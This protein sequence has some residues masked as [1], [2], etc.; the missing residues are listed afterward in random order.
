MR[1]TRTASLALIA[2]LGLGV[3]GCA[4]GTSGTNNEAANGSSVTSSQSP[5][6]LD[7]TG[8]WKQSSDAG[9]GNE[10]IQSATI[11][12][13]TITAYWVTESDEKSLYW[14]GNVEVPE[15]A[16]GEFTWESKNDTSKTATALLASTSDTKSFTYK[17]KTISY[18][19]SALGKT[20]TVELEQT[21]STPAAAPAEQKQQSNDFKV[22]INDATFSQDYEK[23]PVIVVD[24]GFTNNSDET[25][26]FMS[27]VNAQAF[28]GGVELE[29]WA[30][31]VEGLGSEMAM[32]DLKPGASVNVQQPFVLRDESTV[33][34]EVAD[35]LSFDDSV[36]DSQEFSVKK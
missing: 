14:A 11:V 22:T 24:F 1:T 25:A 31:G 8:E 10:S 32:A 36:I 12:N 17:D 4:S 33:T 2:L 21:S 6:Q 9:N 34:V 20:W 35:M 19:V 18:E 15:G 13:N 26:S 3:A 29:G 30:I 27:S 5:A 28:Q 23:N 16:D 7:L